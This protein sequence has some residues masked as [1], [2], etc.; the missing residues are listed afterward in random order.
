[1]ALAL[2]PCRGAAMQTFR[3]VGAM[4][5]VLCA[6]PAS[7]SSSSSVDAL[8]RRLRGE[9][10]TVSVCSIEDL[11]DPASGVDPARAV[12][13]VDGA[14]RLVVAGG[15]GSVGPAASAAAAA[16][17]P[18]AVIATGT[19]NDFARALGLPDEPDDACALAADPDA[20]VRPLDLAAA[21]DRPFV[22]AASAG[23]APAAARTAHPLKGALGPLAYAVGALWAGLT[24]RPLSCAVTVDGESV[25]DGQ[26]WQLVV[27]NT[28]AFG[29][30]SETGG[31]DPADGRLDVAVVPAGPRTALVRRAWGMRTGRLVAQDAVV[32]ARGA[33]IEVRAGDAAFNVDGEVCPCGSPAVFTIRERAVEI[34][35]PAGAGA[36]S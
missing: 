23:L 8:A 3:R 32:H 16:G 26:A 10:A 7:G 2:Y 34:V 25:F 31:T 1:M 33:R 9:G 12:S 13:L 18:L 15:D 4:R 6:N 17:V 35:V 29:G 20:A 28:G 19:A 5:V 30:G 14:Q 21:G 24:T 22:N 27:G 11:G 36:T